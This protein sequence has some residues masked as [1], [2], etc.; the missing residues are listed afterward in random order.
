M[1]EKL[2]LFDLDGT[3]YDTRKVNFFSY[4]KALS[5]YGYDIDYDFFAKECN[6]RHYTEFLPQIMGNS[7]YLDDVHRV[8]KELYCEFL[9]ESRENEHLFNIIDQIKNSYYI[10]LVT[11]ASRKN[12]EEI[13]KYYNRINEFDYIISQEDVKR[14]KPNPE[15][16]IKAMEHYNIS[17][18]N[19]L[20]FED[21]DIGFEAAKQ[22]GA[23]VFLVRGY[24]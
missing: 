22:S 23:T 18:E 24:A 2:A 10:V 8:K 3:L 15:G 20:I 1:K 21:S 17:R 5:Q 11:T 9:G 13:L 6:G 19:T 12:A 7:E 14:K 4:K 16:F